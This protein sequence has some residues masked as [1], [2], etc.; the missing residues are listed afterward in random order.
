MTDGIIQKV[1]RE[2]AMEKHFDLSNYDSHEIE[3]RLI[4]EIKKLRLEQI[5][6]HIRC[7]CEENDIKTMLIGDNQ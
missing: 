5:H 6:T 3:L 1:L 7:G 2:Y 4:S